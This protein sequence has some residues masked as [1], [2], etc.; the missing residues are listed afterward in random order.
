V[1]SLSTHIKSHK[2]LIPYPQRL[3]KAKDEKKYRIFFE[4][5]KK[6]YINFSFL[7]AVSDMSS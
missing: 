7:E 2:P 3:V 1:E 5:L 6:L 4:M